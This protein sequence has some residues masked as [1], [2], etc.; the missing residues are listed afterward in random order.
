MPARALRRPLPEL[1]Q[2]EERKGRVRP[3]RR[4]AGDI[5][6]GSIEHLPSKQKVEEGSGINPTPLFPESNTI[7]G[8]MP[9]VG[10]SWRS[11]SPIDVKATSAS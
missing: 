5:H 2:L 4:G 10:K 9:V 7:G 3:R 11:F 6:A 8:R 1:P